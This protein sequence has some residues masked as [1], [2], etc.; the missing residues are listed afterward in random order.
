MIRVLVFGGRGFVGS[1]IVRQLKGFDVYTASRSAKNG[2]SIHVDVTNKKSVDSAIKNN[3]IVINLVGLTPTKKPKGV[4]YYDIHVKGAKNIVDVCKKK[5][6][7]LIHMS[8]LGA[9]VN[10]PTEYFRTKGLGE[11]LVL[12]SGLDVT[13]FCPSIIYDKENELIKLMKKLS[14]TR[15]FPNIPAKVQPVYRRDI[16]RLYVLAV[17]GKIKE[18][19]LEIG[20]PE[21]L[22]IFDMAKLVY[23]SLGYKCFPIPLF[24]VKFGMHFARIFNLAG[25]GKNQIHNLAVDNTTK[26]KQKYINMEKFSKWV[27][28]LTEKNKYL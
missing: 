23:H 20:G 19:R 17:K 25:I 16:A 15:L 27:K 5:H 1:E 6:C 24:L 8:A 3:D 28:K 18:K 7:R 2:K 9:D 26:M 21:V 14:S 22:S 4:T 11:R 12:N 13:I 10:G